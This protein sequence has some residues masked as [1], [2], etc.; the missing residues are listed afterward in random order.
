MIAGLAV[1]YQLYQGIKSEPMTLWSGPLPEADCGVVL[2]GAAG[3]VREGFE[4]L[5]RKKIKKLIVSGVYSEAKLNEV[6][7]YLPFYP[8]VDPNNII[9]EKRS[10]T[11]YGNAQQ[12]IALVEALHCRDIVLMTSQIHMSRA[13][14]IFSAVYPDFIEIKKLSLPNARSERGWW[15]LFVE[16][17]KSYLYIALGRV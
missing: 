4:Y 17:V 6:F 1:T 8:E 12:S 14:R 9:L 3:R 16:L 2:T 11:T 7:P 10:E 15:G 5:A 13:Y